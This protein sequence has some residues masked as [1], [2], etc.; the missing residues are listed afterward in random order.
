MLEDSSKVVGL[1][2]PVVSFQYVLRK[3]QEKLRPINK[4]KQRKAGLRESS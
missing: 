1:G 3:Q 2:L 4:K